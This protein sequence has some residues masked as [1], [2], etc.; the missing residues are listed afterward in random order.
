MVVPPPDYKTQ[1]RVNPRL[2]LDVFRRGFKRADGTFPGILV[3][4]VLIAG[5]CHWAWF[6]GGLTP[7]QYHETVK[8]EIRMLEESIAY[9]EQVVKEAKE[10][11][12]KY[13][14]QLFKMREEKDRQKLA[15]QREKEA[16]KMDKKSE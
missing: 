11:D 15:K 12:E 4:L 9:F 7:K 8:E 6:K 14:Q 10:R 13:I 3:P 16:S 2:R 1:G 5:V